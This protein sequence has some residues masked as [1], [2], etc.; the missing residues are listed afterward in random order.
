MTFKVNPLTELFFDG[1]YLRTYY[2]GKLT[3]TLTAKIGDSYYV[4]SG[5]KTL[6]PFIRKA[7][8]LDKTKGTKLCW[9]LGFSVDWKIA[10]SMEDFKTNYI[11][12]LSSNKLNPG[13]AIFVTKENQYAL[14]YYPFYYKDK[15]KKDGTEKK[16]IKPLFGWIS[17]TISE[18]EKMILYQAVSS[19][20]QISCPIEYWSRI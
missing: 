12:V 5:A 8:I 11:K 17:D 16:R 20:K 1:H 14:M 13:N 19:V 7:K 15:K 18:E 4:H 9:A 3:N 10:S 6:K 2:K